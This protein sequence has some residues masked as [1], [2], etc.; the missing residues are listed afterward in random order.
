[1]FLE[2]IVLVVAFV[3]ALRWFYYQW[4]RPLNLSRYRHERGQ[5]L[6]VVTGATDGI[7]LAFAHILA[8]QGFSVLLVSRNEEKLKAVAEAIQPLLVSNAI[9]EY[10]VSDAA[11]AMDAVLPVL[12][13]IKRLCAP[14]EEQT[15]QSTSSD[16]SI[17]DQK[18]SQ[19][20]FSILV[21]NVGVGQG[22]KRL[23]HE[24]DPTVIQHT[25]TVNCIYPMLLS[26][27]LMPLMDPIFNNSSG[28]RALVINVASVGGLAIT[29]L[30]S[31][32]G[33]TKAFNR[34][35][36]RCMT[37]EYYAHSVDVACVSPGFVESSLTGM[38]KSFICCT[39]RECVRNT[40]RMAPL[41]DFI[42]HWKHCLMY[43]ITQVLMIVTLPEYVPVIIGGIM[44]PA[45]RYIES[46]KRS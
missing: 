26:H 43:W 40:L 12:S 7:G 36:S 20:K 37:A 16:V 17:R 46:L 13:K 39:A 4:I 32:Y 31:V 2:L 25:V 38:K 6:A 45:R 42:P 14:T 15:T 3:A 44:L 28:R 33:A 30:S 10:V 9:V 34:Q 5:S 27:Q 8:E 41:Y 19:L 22:S 23:L 24:L 11:N 29:P 18:S 1:M 35:F 21:N